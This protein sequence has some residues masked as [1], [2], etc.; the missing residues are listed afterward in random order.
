MGFSVTGS[1]VVFFIASIIA[2]GSVSGIFMA[3]TI[4]V[5]ISLSERGIR[6]QD[7]LDTDFT[8]IND[9]E[10]I[11]ISGSDYLFYLKNIGGNKLITTNQS[12]SI[13]VDGEIIT[14]EKYNFTEQSIRPGEV[15]TIYI[16]N[17]VISSGDHTL[18]LVGPN[19][20]DDEF[21]FTI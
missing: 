1:H 19:A 14:A 18:R 2:A 9:N 21:Q 12:F 17:S 4:N 16:D 13:F 3:A 8:I 10:N 5:T 20:V 11:P 15:I 7:L 6:V